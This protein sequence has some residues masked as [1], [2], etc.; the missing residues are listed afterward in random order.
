MTAAERKEKNEA[1]RSSLQDAIRSIRKANQ[2]WPFRHAAGLEETLHQLKA[3]IK[4][5]LPN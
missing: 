3:K 5:Q 4:A 2:L 1:C